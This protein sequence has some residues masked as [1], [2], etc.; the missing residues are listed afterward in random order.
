MD[1]HAASG[2]TA[3]GHAG[4]D[5][6]PGP[7]L[8]RR[9]RALGP[10]RSRDLR[11]A[12]VFALLALALAWIVML[13]LWILVGGDP[14]YGDP[15]ADTAVASSALP[16]EDP[17]AGPAADD[18]VRVLLLQFFPAAMM[19]TP[20]IAAWISVRWVDGIRFREMFS[21][22]GLARRRTEG[23]R[24]PLLGILLWSGI[25]IVATTVL[26][27]LSIA[28]AAL[29]GFLD[30]DWGMPVLAASAAAS[31]I[32]VMVL[33]VLQ[34]VS[35]PVA[36]VLPNGLFAAGEEIG[37]RGYLLPRL[38]RLWGTPA[39]VMV[40][41]VIWGLWHAPIILLGYNFMRP[42]A[43]GVLLMIAGCIAVGAWLIWLTVRSGTV[44][45]AVCGHGALNASAGFY[46]IMSSTPD[47]DGAA[48][49]PLGAAG[50]IAFGLVGAVLLT[51]FS[52]R[53]RAGSPV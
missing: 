11:G 43:G 38:V 48:A 47:V 10:T 14:V 35:V 18:I 36:A 31:G 22:L 24:H 46:L 12:A 44:W 27:A 13:P 25:A 19:L 45:P 4:D 30:V 20:A 34:L 37:W 52:G 50:W 49:G 16:G 17:A 21:E 51:F 40:S 42:H 6:T 53:R 5:S 41:G 29:C 1:G 2:D 9:F 39:A 32:P 28:V 7:A 23:A 8:P 33:F 3:G 26:V 15:G